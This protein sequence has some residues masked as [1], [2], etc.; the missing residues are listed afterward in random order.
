MSQR[1]LVEIPARF[2]LR[3]LCGEG[4]IENLGTG[5]LFIETA[6]VPERGQKI[7][8]DFDAPNGEAV[9][10]AGLVWWTTLD[11]DRHHDRRGFGIRL[12]WASENYG[13]LLDALCAWAEGHAP[14]SS[15]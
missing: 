10:A 7:W 1:F 6:T 14:S 9:E 8:I 2:E 11:G 4:S 5:G 12:V 3:A 13:R 15:R